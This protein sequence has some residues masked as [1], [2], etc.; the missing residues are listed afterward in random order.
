MSRLRIELEVRALR[1]RMGIRMRRGLPASDMLR[2]EALDLK[3]RTPHIDQAYLQERLLVLLRDWRIS[4][5]VRANPWLIVPHDF[6][7]MPATLAGPALLGNIIVTGDGRVA[8]IAEVVTRDSAPSPLSLASMRKP[9]TLMA[10]RLC[11]HEESG[12]MLASILCGPPFDMSLITLSAIEP[13]EG[14][15]VIMGQCGLPTD[16]A[17]TLHGGA[18]A[19]SLGLEAHHHGIDLALRSSTVRIASTLG[20]TLLTRGHRMDAVSLR[21]RWRWV[22]PRNRHRP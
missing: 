5:L 19:R 17:C 9:C 15:A 6:Y 22:L 20:R 14:V 18:V 11:L 21:P 3:R 16:G 4:L 7:R 13:L 1:A 2:G 8:R 12:V 10:G